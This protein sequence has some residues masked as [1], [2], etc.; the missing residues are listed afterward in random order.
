MHP[1]LLTLIH[2]AIAAGGLLFGC[3]MTVVVASQSSM[4]GA[5]YAVW[6]F[7]A[8]GVIGLIALGVSLFQRA[9]HVGMG[10]RVFW[11]VLY[12]AGAAG[13]ALLFGVMTMIATN[14]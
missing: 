2:L 5:G 3:L 8:V 14:R 4:R 6:T 12:G 1:F 11:V 9:A 10:Q 7:A 13:L